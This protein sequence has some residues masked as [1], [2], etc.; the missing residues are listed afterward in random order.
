MTQIGR[1]F[2]VPTPPARRIKP[3]AA[4]SGSDFSNDEQT[5]RRDSARRLP[6]PT[7][8]AE[9]REQE[10][11]RARLRPPSAALVVQLIA[12]APRRGLK[13][14]PLEQDRYRRAYADRAAAPARGPVLEKTA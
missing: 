12:G 14:E 3:A 6:V 1:T 2:S 13:A 8:R 5:P 10:A 4:A 11:P 7:A 9:R